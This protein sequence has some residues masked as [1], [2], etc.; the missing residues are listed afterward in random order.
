MHGLYVKRHD[1][2]VKTIHEAICGGGLQK[3]AVLMDAGKRVELPEAV[4]NTKDALAEWI[5]RLSPKPIRAPLP[6]ITA[7]DIVIFHDIT[8]DDVDHLMDT[9]TR[10]RTGQQVTIIEV[11]YC[12]DTDASGKLAEKQAQ[13]KTLVET[14]NSLGYR[15]KSYAIPLGH[16]GMVYNTIQDIHNACNTDS[17]TMTRLCRKLSKHATRYAHTIVA[18]RRL[19]EAEH[20]HTHSKRQR[21][22]NG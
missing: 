1:D 12:S 9:G 16:T 11:G 14:L 21:E 5:T 19:H 20:K 8:R 6:Y 10:M 13:H 22:A 3:A 15:A 7:P 2:A 18:T 17:C 4:A